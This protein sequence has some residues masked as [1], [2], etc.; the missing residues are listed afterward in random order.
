VTDEENKR[1]V[2]ELEKLGGYDGWRFTYEYPGF[3]CYSHHQLPYTVSCTPDWSKDGTLPIE[4]QDD[5]GR[6]FAEHS[7]VLSFPAEG[8]TGQKIFDLVQPT[9]DKLRA[10]PRVIEV[11]VKLT[12]EEI[13]AL[14]AAR[15]YVREHMAVKHPWAVRDAAM[16]GIGKVLEAVRVAQ[17]S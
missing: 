4:V 13:V 11:M 3:F 17:K 15:N 16:E 6:F 2:A 14:K 8:R 1:L 9:L 12:E 7:T 10:L 5:H